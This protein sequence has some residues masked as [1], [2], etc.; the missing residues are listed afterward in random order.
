MHWDVIDVKVIAPFT[1]HVKF[2][3]GTSGTVIFKPES[4]YGVFEPLKD[5]KFFK[6][7]YIDGDAVAWP[8]DLDVAPDAMYQEIKKHGQ[9]VIK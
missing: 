3:D 8:C 9:W 7:V 2:K 6:K 5:P 1:L 4:L